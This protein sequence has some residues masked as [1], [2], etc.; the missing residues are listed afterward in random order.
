MDEPK[1]TLVCAQCGQAFAAFLTDM[2]EHN[3]EVVCPRCGK[4]YD[5]PAALALAQGA[6]RKK[7]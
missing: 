3:A 1:I 7:I 4:V 5:P 6:P 2:A